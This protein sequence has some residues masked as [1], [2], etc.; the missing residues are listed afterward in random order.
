MFQRMQ[1]EMDEQKETAGRISRHRYAQIVR[2]VSSKT[3]CCQ[4]I[5]I[6]VETMMR[7][8]KQRDDTSPV[9]RAAAA[10]WSLNLLSTQ[11]PNGPLT[12]ILE[13]ILPAVYYHYDP[14]RL[15]KVP[16]IIKVQLGDEYLVKWNPFFSHSMLMEEVDLN[17]RKLV[18]LYS[19]LNR[20]LKS[21]DSRRNH[22]LRIMTSRRRCTL[23][24]AFRSWHMLARRNRLLEVTNLN[25]MKRFIKEHSRL[26]LSAAFYQWKLIL[27]L[28]RNTFLMERL[29]ESA[30]QLE[31]AKNQFQ[32][33]CCRADRLIQATKESKRELEEA[34]RENEELQALVESLKGE[35]IERE[36]E[37][38]KQFACS[39]RE[40]SKLVSM[41]SRF[42][43]ILITT[44]RQP[45]PYQLSPVPHSIVQDAG[46]LGADEKKDQCY[47][48]DA[49]Q[50]LQR[51][52]NTIR[53]EVKG[54]NAE[55]IVTLGV[56]F[57]SGEVYRILLNYVFSQTAVRLD[58]NIDIIDRL[59]EIKELCE[60]YGLA[61]VLE[62][63]DFINLREDRIM[64]SLCELYERY[65]DEK[66]KETI[67]KASIA[68]KKELEEADPEIPVIEMDFSSFS[69]LVKRSQH[70]L[71]KLRNQAISQCNYEQELVS[72]K[73][74]VSE[75]RSYLERERCNGAPLAH[76]SKSSTKLFWTLN[77]KNLHDIQHGSEIQIRFEAIIEPLQAALRSRSLQT[78]RIFYAYANKDTRTMSEFA[79]WRFI[80]Y[81]TILS[82][83]LT[84]E[85]VSNIFD[86]VASPQLTTV[87]NLTSQGKLDV[88]KKALIRVARQEMD[89]RYV[90][91]EQ[92][93][94]ILVR[95]SASKYGI[96][97]EIEEKLNCFFEQTRFP[98]KGDL[99]SVLE[100]FY[101]YEVQRVIE[102][103]STD[104]CRVF[105]FY[106][107]KQETSS[108][109]SERSMAVQSGGRFA[110]LLASSF[111]LRMLEDCN[112]LS[113][114]IS[115]PNNVGSNST[116]DS[117]PKRFI[118]SS[119]VLNMMHMLQSNYVNVMPDQVTF[120]IFLESLSLI[121]H[122]W[123]PNPLVPLSRKLAAFIVVCIRQLNT[124]HS[125]TTLILAE[126]PP[127]PL[128]G[129]K[130]V[131]F[132]VTNMS[133]V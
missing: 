38:K 20:A 61:T 99:P 105:F 98:R 84:K 30:F 53:K 48:E 13:A 39:A 97:R 59:Q 69:E 22:I 78:S 132:N 82:E 79:F 128:T 26:L 15:T 77:P 133:D 2:Q 66:W 110:A 75:A 29:H 10:T 47:Q 92:F 71:G 21:N 9:L 107:K 35:L 32:L 8:L 67:N 108:T 23:Q 40:A 122:Y 50:L 58:R 121:A 116:N 27:E 55:G 62:P 73:M 114:G 24:T 65:L 17:E 33:Q 127:I 130:R 18:N 120:T 113:D 51:W 16:Q 129:G 112:F 81:S 102:F 52:C 104:L 94:E 46:Q 103:F 34:K 123:C 126:F 111:F 31:N 6:F 54:E 115:L 44:H 106:L 45:L 83:K 109:T 14:S 72:H 87:F 74:M 85:I 76:L 37:Y 41:Y 43:S 42:S 3:G 125:G 80:E 25:K 49:L 64:Q 5:S 4:S 90:T 96:E 91:P 36:G 86:R 1:D 19:S 11:V 12:F 57:A 56:D 68:L 118:S 28:S 7:E 93:I 89:I 95:M 63:D 100:A 60:A 131:D 119:E 88:D 101:E 117:S 124:F 70:Q